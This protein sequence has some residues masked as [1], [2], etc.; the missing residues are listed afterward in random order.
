MSQEFDLQ[1]LGCG[2]NDCGN[3]GALCPTCEKSFTA[4]TEM[5]CLDKNPRCSDKSPCDFCQSIAQ[6]VIETKGLAIGGGKARDVI[7]QQGFLNEELCED[8]GKQV[9]SNSTE[10]QV[11]AFFKESAEIAQNGDLNPKVP[12]SVVFQKDVGPRHGDLCALTPEAVQAFIDFMRIVYISSDLPLIPIASSIPD[13]HVGQW[14]GC[15]WSSGNCWLVVILQMFQTGTWHTSINVSNP[16]GNALWIL[17]RELRMIG[18]VSRQR[19]QAF[20][21][22]MQEIIGQPEEGSLFEKG[23][24]DPF[25]VL[26]MLETAGVFLYD[27]TLS[28]ESFIQG[29]NATPVVDLGLS[30]SSSTNLIE[31]IGALNIDIEFEQ[32]SKFSCLPSILVIKVSLSERNVGSTVDF[33]AS[34]VF[35]LGPLTFQITSV[36]L[37]IKDHYLTGFNRLRYDPQTDTLSATYW[38]S[39]SKSDVQDCGHHVPLIKEIDQEQFE[40]LWRNHA[41]S[42]TCVRIPKIVQ[43]DGIPHELNG[44]EYEPLKPGWD[45]LP[46]C[47]RGKYI[48]FSQNEG[49][50]IKDCMSPLEFQRTFSPPPPAPCA[51]GP[52]VPHAPSA[53]VSPPPPPPVPCAQVAQA[54][55][56]P[57]PACCVVWFG[58]DY[59]IYDPVN[60]VLKSTL[61]G[62]IIDDIRAGYYD[63]RTNDTREFIQIFL[64]E[65]PSDDA[66]QPFPQPIVLPNSIKKIEMGDI[67]VYQGEWSIR[68]DSFIMKGTCVVALNQFTIDG[69]NYN[70]TNFLMLLNIL[71]KE[72]CKGKNQ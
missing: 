40:Y 53:H 6:S 60:N 23:Q 59:R 38:L 69:M 30:P 13:S 32:E 64:K 72:H 16:L 25:E 19:L 17:V 66:S 61:T 70:Q 39:D 29:I 56:P 24:M 33:P 1:K 21:R 20:R 9:G 10:C 44:S 12:T 43:I 46:Q 45:S 2:Q 28:S 31:K 36:M 37:F 54:L 47:Y 52:C 58:T 71:Y 41:I 15:E 48:I 14:R 4:S 42:I 63:V 57:P 18:F 65:V 11:C 51:S 7:P 35:D 62:R 27:Y 22:L 34:S 8:C 49:M 67:T 3:H 50:H 26:K 5:K 68:R 55:P